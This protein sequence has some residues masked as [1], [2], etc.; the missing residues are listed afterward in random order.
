MAKA[1]KMAKEAFLRN[2][3]SHQVGEA[4]QKGTILLIPVGQ[5]EEDGYCIDNEEQ[6]VFL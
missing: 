3:H 6:P 5:T 4:T 2:L 1:L